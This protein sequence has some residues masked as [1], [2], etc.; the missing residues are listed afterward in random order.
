VKPLAFAS[1]LAVSSGTV[2]SNVIGG[3]YE[4]TDVLG[5]GAS[6]TVYAGKNVRTG[7]RVAIKSLNVSVMNHAEDP[8]LRRFEQEARIAGSIESQHIAQVFDIDTDPDTNETFLVMELLAGEDVE[9][10]IGRVGA[11]PPNVA[12]CIAAEACRGLEAAHA[13]GVV[14]RDIKPGNLFLSRRDGDDI[15][16]KVLDFGLAKIKRFAPTDHAKGLTAPPESITA[17]GQLLGSPLYMSPEHVEGASHVDAQS[18]VYSLGVTLHAMLA[19]APP[20]ADCKSFVDLLHRITAEKPRP[21]RDVAPWVPPDV[22]AIVA[23]AMHVS[24]S[25]RFSSAAAMREA[26]IAVLPNDFSLRADMLVTAD[27]TPVLSNEKGDENIEPANPMAST[28]GAGSLQ[29][30]RR[31]VAFGVSLFLIAAMIIALLRH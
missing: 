14:H 24:R 29:R 7:R 2:S 4:I 10:L 3:K 6:G 1:R 28:D 30:R 20:H 9:T 27:R 31:I 5:R 22:A 11:L 21:L 13:A 19:G 18:D 26:I 16:V 23:K 12:L 25:E 8:D 17:T 15:V